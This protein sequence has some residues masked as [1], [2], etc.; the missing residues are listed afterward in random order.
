[1]AVPSAAELVEKTVSAYGMKLGPKAKDYLMAVFKE[2]VSAWSTW[3][4][5]ISFGQLSVSGAGT[6]AWSGTG[7]GGVMVGKMPFKMAT[8]YFEQ[9]SSQQRQFT[10]AFAEALKDK[11]TPWPASFKFSAL[12]YTGTCGATSTSPGPVSA[13][14]V[15]TPLSTAGKGTNPSGIF[16]LW[17]PKLQPPDWDLGNPQAKSEPLMKAMAK[18]VEDAFANKWLSNTKATSDSFS[19]TAPPNGVIPSGTSSETGGKLT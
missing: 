17:R 7:S 3:E 6:G 11:F 12:T 1:M 16:G 8:V 19:A 4:S 18:A 5:G 14:C 2:V 9:N 15:A 10:D 13:S